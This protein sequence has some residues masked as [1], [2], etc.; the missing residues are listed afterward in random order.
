M[1]HFGTKLR[2]MRGLRDVTQEGLAT[3]SGVNAAYINRFE[4]GRQNPTADEERRIREA[5]E[6]TDEADALLGKLGSQPVTS[7]A[8][9]A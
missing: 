1:L 3:L 5:L 4:S 8:H 9:C 2:M 6:W 7:Q